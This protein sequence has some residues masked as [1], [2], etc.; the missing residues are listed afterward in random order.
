[1]LFFLHHLLLQRMIDL[2]TQQCEHLLSSFTR[3]IAELASEGAVIRQSLEKDRSTIAR[4]EWLAIV[5][6]LQAHQVWS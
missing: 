4:E 1:M 3:H 6:K 5:G 2:S